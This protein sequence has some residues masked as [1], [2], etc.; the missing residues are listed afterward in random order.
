MTFVFVRCES[1]C[2]LAGVVVGSVSVGASVYVSGSDWVSAVLSGV[3]V[4]SAPV[5]F[6][7]FSV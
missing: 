2:V 7:S 1:S 3:M 5:A 4:A 6:N